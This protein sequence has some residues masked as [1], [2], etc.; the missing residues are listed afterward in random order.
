V[1]DLHRALG[2]STDDPD[3]EPAPITASDV[4]RWRAEIA[5]DLEE[6]FDG[7]SAYHGE[8][9]SQTRALASEVLAARTVLRERVNAF[10][11]PHLRARKSRF[12]GDLH[13]GQLLVVQND[14]VITDFE[15]EPGR[16]LHER[17]RKHS[18]LK[19][20]AGMLRS[21]S[22]VAAAA[23][24]Q[25]QEAQGG[26]RRA[27]EEFMQQWEE[28]TTTRFLAAYRE[29]M[30]GSPSYPADQRD[31]EQMLW[32]FSLEKALYELRYEQ[33]QRPAWLHI[34]LRALAGMARS[35]EA[36]MV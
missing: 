29:A 28:Q 27:T 14:L 10:E 1:A 7:L 30:Q 6:M 19:D 11:L 21:F 8:I 20:V 23:G 31:A 16:P 15:G 32:I 33:T 9:T 22:Y 36:T 26:D 5:E 35:E 17:R 3:F 34:P 4:Q 25:Q 13:L 24:T 2:A 12:H 18:P